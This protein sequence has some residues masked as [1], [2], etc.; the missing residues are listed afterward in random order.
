MDHSMNEQR[1]VARPPVEFGSFRRL[2][3]ISRL[4]GSDRGQPIDRR[5]IENFLKRHAGDMRGRVL[6]FHG[7]SY[8]RLLGGSRVTES[9]VLNVEEGTRSQ[10]SSVI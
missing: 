2:T 3:P 5:Y 9:D 10:L 6:E 1:I 4:W 8:T 7:N